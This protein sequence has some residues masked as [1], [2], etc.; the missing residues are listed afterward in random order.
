MEW[1]VGSWGRKKS[2]GS[3]QARLESRCRCKIVTILIVKLGDKKLF[4]QV[5]GSKKNLLL[6][7]HLNVIYFEKDNQGLLVTYT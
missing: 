4:F 1:S 5:M 6:E 2:D 3:C 7:E